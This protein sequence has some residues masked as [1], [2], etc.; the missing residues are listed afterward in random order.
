M[1]SNNGSIDIAKVSQP[2]SSFCC[3][4]LFRY[5]S[6]V[7]LKKKITRVPNRESVCSFWNR[8]FI[9]KRGPIE[10]EDKSV[11]ETV[12]AIK[13]SRIRREEK[14]QRDIDLQI[15]RGTRTRD[16]IYSREDK[17]E[18]RDEIIREKISLRSFDLAL[19]SFCFFFSK[20]FVE[21][22]SI[23]R[24]YPNEYLP[25]YFISIRI[26]PIQLIFFFHFV[27]CIASNCNFYETP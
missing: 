21:I 25:I 24:K 16:F 2:L 1:I 8:I 19:Q 23:F 5:F 22:F 13:N 7:R 20:F 17:T 15:K 12:Y 27:C 11:S 9:D 4:Q 26:I 6:R 10:A 18:S 3:R 14:K